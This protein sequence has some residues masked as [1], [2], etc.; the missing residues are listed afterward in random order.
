MLLLQIQILTS[1]C[2]M[3]LENDKASFYFDNNWQCMNYADIHSL[4]HAYYI[5]TSKE[6]IRFCICYKVGGVCIFGWV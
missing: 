6:L 2:V 5:E 3:L 4:C 1:K